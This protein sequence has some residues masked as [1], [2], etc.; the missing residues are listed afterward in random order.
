MDISTSQPMIPL[1][2]LAKQMQPDAMLRGKIGVSS[3]ATYTKE[4][5]I[6]NQYNKQFN[7]DATIDDIVSGSRII[8]IMQA[9]PMMTMINGF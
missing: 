7:I 8:A 9:S 1:H 6:R 2:V 3:E 5:A 4:D